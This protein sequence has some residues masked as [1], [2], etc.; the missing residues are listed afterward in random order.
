M[1]AAA[2]VHTGR[3]RRD[4]DPV[5]VCVEKPVRGS[6][7]KLPGLILIVVAAVATVVAGGCEAT[8]TTGGTTSFSNDQYGFSF[9]IVDRFEKG[10][11]A[12]FS[13]STGAADFN[14]AFLDPDGAKAGDQ[15]ID[16]FMVSVYVLKQEITPD[17]MPELKTELENALKQL[18]AADPSVQMQPL[19][20]TT[21][22]GVP[23]WKTD[24]TMNVNGAPVQDR[25]YFLVKGTNEYQ[26]TMQSST[27]NWA[28][29]E[30]D[31]Q[32]AADSFTVK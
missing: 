11:S 24:Y 3:P 26:I 20:D 2:E 18:A 13:Q 7:V 5:T 27:D 19:V 29:N 6:H 1:S 28:K 25:A 16:A 4:A 23:G 17:L 10:D 14:V 22:N 32:K 12:Q 9:K 30:P 31:L 8:V 15:S 21:V